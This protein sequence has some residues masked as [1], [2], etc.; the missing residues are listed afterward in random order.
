MCGRFYFTTSVDEVRGAFPQLTLPETLPARAQVTPGQAVPVIT[1]AAPEALQWFRWGLVPAWA[2]D[3]SIGHRL[4]NARAETLDEKPAFRTAL[5]ARRCLILA[6]GFYEWPQTGAKTPYRIRLTSGALLAFAGLW[7]TWRAPDGTPLYTCT[8]IT[9]A[10]NALMAPIHHRMPVILPPEDHAAW[11]AP[12]PQPADRLLPLLR[13][14]PA[15]A[16]FA[17]PDAL[18]ARD[19][20]L[21]LPF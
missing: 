11:L 9:T 1:N 8:L 3:A 16:M 10:A 2:T 21:A 5:K 4:I 7:D 15:E 19:A 13:Q 20:S 17:A 14:Y 6:S 18:P 12:T